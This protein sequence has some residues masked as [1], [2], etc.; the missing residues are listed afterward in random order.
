MVL[1]TNLFQFQDACLLMSIF[2]GMFLETYCLKLDISA[3]PKCGSFGDSENDLSGIRTLAPS[4]IRPG[5]ASCRSLS[6]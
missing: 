3:A 1:I 4:N 2:A 6:R 5:L